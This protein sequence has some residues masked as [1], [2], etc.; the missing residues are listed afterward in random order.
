VT[1]AYQGWPGAFSEVAALERF[2]PKAAPVGFPTFEAAV[3]AAADGTARAVLV[4]VR[5]S[6]T[7]AVAGAAEAVALGLALGLRA[8]GDVF[9]A[10][11]HALLALPGVGLGQVRRVRS[12][13]Q[14]LA[15]CA[16]WLAA[17]VP[18]AHVGPG[19]ADAPDTAGAA[20]EVAVRGLR[21]TA[22]VAHADAA[23]RYGLAVLADDVADRADNTT[24]FAV[25]VRP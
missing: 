25:L 15:Q 4:P 20:R 3:R 19:P 14:A 10:V 22:A 18:R 24:T 21:D 5:N 13:P 9:L 16:G 2:G 8:D 11:R 17:N 12:H 7:G 23:L 1:V 6:T